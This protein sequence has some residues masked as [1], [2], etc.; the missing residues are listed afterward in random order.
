MSAVYNIPKI[1]L[2]VN[3]SYIIMQTPI[4]KQLHMYTYEVLKSEEKQNEISS[5]HNLPNVCATQ[6]LTFI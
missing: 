1:K 4:Y 2:N 3:L 5:H 6:V